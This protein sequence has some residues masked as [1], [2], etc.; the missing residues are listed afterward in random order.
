M[1][2]GGGEMVQFQA[3][4]KVIRALEMGVC[5]SGSGQV[6]CSSC[7]YDVVIYVL[8]FVLFIK[9]YKKR[10]V[11]HPEDIQPTVGSIGVNMGQHP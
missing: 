11:H 9:S 4:L 8:C 6:G 7:L 3:M 5:A 2:Y 10:M 1:G